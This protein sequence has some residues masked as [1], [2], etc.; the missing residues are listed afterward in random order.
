MQTA[1]TYYF[2]LA[3]Y[4]DGLRSIRRVDSLGGFRVWLYR[5]TLRPFA[6]A[7]WRFVYDE[8]VRHGMI[9]PATQPRP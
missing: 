7:W 3:P 6:L 5:V 2:R 9:D 1:P 4:L 8:A